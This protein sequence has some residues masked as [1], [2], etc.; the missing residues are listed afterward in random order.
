MS[1][2]FAL[3]A[4]AIAVNDEGESKSHI[5]TTLELFYLNEIESCVSNN[6]NEQRYQIMTEEY[7]KSTYDHRTLAN[8]IE[9]CC[10]IIYSLQH[11]DSC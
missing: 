5:Y 9:Y 11:N 6:N 1:T 2:A 8:W 7:K 3:C 10:Q 4:A